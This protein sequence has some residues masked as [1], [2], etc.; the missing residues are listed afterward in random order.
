MLP[1]LYP[2]C[3]IL[4]MPI[5]TYDSWAENH[6][7]QEQTQTQTT[8]LYDSSRLSTIPQEPEYPQE[9]LDLV[10]EAHAREDLH[11]ENHRARVFTLTRSVLRR[12]FTTPYVNFRIET[13]TTL[14]EANE[15]AMDIFKHYCGTYF[16]DWREV[17]PS[18]SSGLEGYH[19]AGWHVGTE[20]ELYLTAFDGEGAK[21][22]V[23]IRYRDR[24]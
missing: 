2:Q 13:F 10:D 18:N 3:P 8:A 5:P 14:E 19:G 22:W 20:G 15:A 16:H 9:L 7:S 24:E 21:F 12:D 4:K 17:N 6:A 1:Q 23:H 11:Q